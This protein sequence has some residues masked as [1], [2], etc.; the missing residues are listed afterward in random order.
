MTNPESLCIQTQD[1]WRTY[2]A[3]TAQ[4]VHALKSLS[5]EI[6]TGQLVAL[7]GRSGSGKTTLLNCIGSLD[8]PT[9]GNIKV[10]GQE[11]SALSEN[12]LTHFRRSQVSFIFQSFGLNPLFTAYE[13]IE[14]IL[15]IVQPKGGQTSRERKQMTLQ[16]LDLVGMSRWQHHRPDELSGGQQQRIA[17]ARALAPLPRLIL[18]DE[19]TGDL[20]TNTAREIMSIFRR[21]V[22][23]QKVSLLVSSHD[24]LINR[25]ADRVLE[26][27]S[28]ELIHDTAQTKSI[29]TEVK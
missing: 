1:L 10:F 28:G 8:K 13:N 21:I 7:R 24:P 11:I 14:L 27:R 19:P 5:L 29:S 9:K 25:Y 23:E 16:A 3:G 6:P 26:L 18:A 4:E 20:D 22:D 12:D 2:R 15:R 17:I